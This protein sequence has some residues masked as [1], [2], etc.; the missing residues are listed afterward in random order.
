MNKEKFEILKQLIACLE[1][2]EN[3]VYLDYDLVEKRTK[4]RTSQINRIEITEDNIMLE[5]EASHT[6]RQYTYIRFDEKDKSFFIGDGAEK[7]AE[8]KIE[9]I[10][11]NDKKLKEFFKNLSL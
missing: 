5:I 11:D 4:T 2:K 6:Y 9:S 3:I 7:K 1:N 8:E 10:Q